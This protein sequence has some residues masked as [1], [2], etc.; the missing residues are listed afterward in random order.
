MAPGCLLPSSGPR[1]SLQ[2]QGLQPQ[3]VSSITSSWAH[4]KP[5]QIEAAESTVNHDEDK[6]G[7]CLGLACF[8]WIAAISCGVV[9]YRRLATVT[10]DPWFFVLLISMCLVS[11]ALWVPTETYMIQFRPA[12]DIAH[13][14]HFTMQSDQ[15]I[16]YSA[17]GSK[18]ADSSQRASQSE[19][20][21]S[22]LLGR[23]PPCR[24]QCICQ[25]QTEPQSRPSG[26]S[27]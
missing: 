9:Q 15:L 13:R 18:G 25:G 10:F 19:P 2:Q 16:G 7:V 27:R 23:H 14:Q 11:I 20:D 26:D 3:R 12:N 17:A 4:A 5:R 21:P 8:V 6:L 22:L 24:S 1:S